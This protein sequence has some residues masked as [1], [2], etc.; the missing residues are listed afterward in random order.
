MQTRRCVLLQGE[1]TELGVTMIKALCCTE[2]LADVSESSAGRNIL[3]HW[4]RQGNPGLMACDKVDTKYDRRLLFLM[5]TI[6][7]ANQWNVTLR[8]LDP[9][10]PVGVKDVIGLF[11]SRFLGFLL[12]ILLRFDYRPFV[13]PSPLF[14]CYGKPLLHLYKELQRFKFQDS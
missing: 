7:A 5:L 11:F 12:S 8:E 9:I 6:I 1:S 2:M 10:R 14:V 4:T 13:Q 3:T